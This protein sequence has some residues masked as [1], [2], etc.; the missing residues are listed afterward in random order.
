MSTDL[1]PHKIAI[2]SGINDSPIAP[3]VNK[4]GNGSHLI[5]KF[6]NLINDLQTA[7]DD[8]KTNGATLTNLTTIEQSLVSL[9]GRVEVLEETISTLPSLQMIEALQEGIDLLDIRL[10]F[11]E[12]QQP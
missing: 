9:R 3:T 2:I 6:N 11:L 5:S 12:E 8:I 4:G 10:T 7:L 1:T